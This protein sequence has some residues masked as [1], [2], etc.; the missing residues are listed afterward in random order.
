MHIIKQLGIIFVVCLAGELISEYLPFTFPGSVS[1]MVL[2]L[3]LLAAG[4]IKVGQVE[5]TANFLVANMAILFIPLGVGII[6]CYHLIS[7]Q[8][9][10]LILICFI[11][12]FLTFAASGLAAKWMLQWQKRR[13]GTGK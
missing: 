12:T 2:M 4:V 13:G 9:W 6:E 10:L 11:T 3:A 1:S 7:R 5:L 8:V